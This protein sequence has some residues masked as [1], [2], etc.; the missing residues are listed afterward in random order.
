MLAAILEAMTG[1]TGAVPSPYTLRR[2]KAAAAKL[3][4][5]APDAGPDEVA[6]AAEDW[7]ARM[8]R[9]KPDH[10]PITADQ[11]VEAVTVLASRPRRRRFIPHI[12][13]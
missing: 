4:R 3:A 5:V 12:E 1:A 11:L 7:Q 6:A 13:Y 9:R 8:A 10:D 2:A